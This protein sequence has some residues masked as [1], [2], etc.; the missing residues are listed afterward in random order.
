MWESDEWTSI[1]A[2]DEGSL[3]GGE[4]KAT[5][6]VLRIL[7]SGSAFCLAGKCIR[8]RQSDWAAI[9]PHVIARD[10]L[11]ES[12]GQISSVDR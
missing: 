4:R 5:G 12:A 8:H 2:G 10:V 3:E 1:A 11:D 6:H 9:M 7:P